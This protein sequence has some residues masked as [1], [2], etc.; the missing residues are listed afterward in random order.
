MQIIVKQG[1]RRDLDAVL[2]EQGEISGLQN[3]DR[4]DVILV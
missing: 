3:L 4:R 1:L 2:N